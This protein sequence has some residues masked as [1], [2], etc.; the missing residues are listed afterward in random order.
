MRVLVVGLGSMGKRRVRNLTALGVSNIAGFD[1]RE[2]RVNDAILNYGITGFSSFENAISE[3]TPDAVV[4]STSPQH[5]MDYAFPLVEANIPIFIEA[6]VV[7]SEQILQ[8]SKN[9]ENKRLVVAPSCTMRF[10]P[11]P[12]LIEKLLSDEVIG[13]VL[14]FN[15]HVG[16]WLPDWHP[17]ENIKDFYA[18]SR[19]TGGAREIVP[20]EL[21]WLNPIFG[22]PIIKSAVVKKL[23]ELD[24]DIDD[25]YNFTIEYP[26]SVIANITIDVISR[27]KATRELRIIGTEGTL[28]FSS[29][30]GYVKY[31]N[32]NNPEWTMI[33]L[34]SGTVENGY[35]YQEEPY[36]EEL[37]LFLSAVE[38]NNQLLYPNNLEQDFRVLKSLL[39]IEL[40]SGEK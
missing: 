18:S 31:S 13:K 10:F 26:K 24:A 25:F 28:V 17:W 32:L 23:S 19:E 27:P 4:I 20:F 39:E 37:N 5:H 16:Q 15:Y 21:T 36:I 2:D 8:L 29:D 11:G 6:S 40:M 14:S 12:K 22:E 33:S 3:F 30:H 1:V 38:N 35:I 9:I 7:D 34:D